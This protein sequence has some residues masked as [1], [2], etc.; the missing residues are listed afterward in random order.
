MGKW[1]EQM[2]LSAHLNS[3]TNILTK[4]C[5]KGYCKNGGKCSFENG[6]P[7]CECLNSSFTGEKCEKRVAEDL[8]NPNPCLNDGQ[9]HSN[10]TTVSCFCLEAF[11]GSRCEIPCKCGTNELCR[12]SIRSPG[13]AECLTVPEPELIIPDNN[14]FSF[15]ETTNQIDDDETTIITESQP[16][17]T[18]TNFSLPSTTLLTQNIN[19]SNN[20]FEVTPT[21]I[22]SPSSSTSFE[23]PTTLKPLTPIPTTT[24]TF[25]PNLIS[26]S[27]IITETDTFD[28]LLN[29]TS[30]D[31]CVNAQRCL[32]MDNRYICL[33]NEGYTG[34]YCDEP[35]NVCTSIS[36]KDGQV[37]RLQ[38][39][40]SI[41]LPQCAC[42]P[43]FFGISCHD[44]TTASFKPSSILIYQ[45]QSKPLKDSEYSLILSFRTTVP[46]VH[47]V[48]GENLFGK[49]QFSLSLHSGFLTISIG[50]TQTSIN[51]LILDDGEWYTIWFNS[52]QTRITVEI[53]ESAS[54]YILTRK[55]LQIKPINIYTT[56]FGRIN[57]DESSFVGCLRDVFINQQLVDLLSSD[58]SVDIEPGCNR[59]DQCKSDTCQNGAKCIDLWDK[60]RCECVRPFLEP[61]CVNQLQEVTFGHDNISSL[62]EFS[63]DANDSKLIRQKTDISF[64]I[65]S[66]NDDGIIGFF[67]NRSD[68]DDSVGTFLSFEIIDG[69]FVVN[70]R[71]G[72]KRIVTEKSEKSINDNKIH[73]IEIQRSGNDLRLKID[74][75]QEAIL[76]FRHPFEHPLLADSLVLGDRTSI[77]QEAAFTSPSGKHFKG[78]L[79]D[80]RINGKSVIL[81][82]DPPTF[83]LES[84]GQK[85]IDQNILEGTVSD[86]IC[87]QLNPCQQGKCFNTFNDFECQCDSGW[88]GLKCEKK[89]FC[90]DKPCP[91]G[92][93]CENSHGGYVC[94]STASF[95]PTS[96]VKYS[97][98]LPEIVAPSKAYANFTIQ[99]RTRSKIGQIFKLQSSLD[100]I[101]F[102]LTDFGIDVIYSNSTNSIR[103][104]LALPISDGQWHTFSLQELNSK[105]SAEFDTFPSTP[106]LA[107]FSLTRFGIDK[108]A[109]LVLG[110]GFNSTG[111]KGCLQKITFNDFP[112]ISF[113]PK[114]TFSGNLNTVLHFVPIQRENIQS[115]GCHSTEK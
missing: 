31:S 60:F 92:S 112:E 42:A 4:Q 28:E 65:R 15:L 11:T 22:V 55:Q 115:D 113:L 25:N 32:E 18:L 14:N 49:Q 78:T 3:T 50:N 88:I 73:L 38:R 95:Y 47:F 109:R 69:K 90:I 104:P 41:D 44:A 43:G 46:N 61:M 93:T 39:T 85:Q 16:S 34:A 10:G 29:V 5:P 87:A 66:K 37:C 56:R 20:S 80:I 74:G 35:S 107:P 13:T 72:G 59:K 114:D 36:C 9:C 1:C 75:K 57:E 33:C 96:V 83:N 111:F 99:I 105:L 110:K 6:H 64:L 62:I 76:Q 17:T 82:D 98:K 91:F 77:K 40:G 100:S 21:T 68:D 89:D 84:F 67:G 54:G 53:E 24:T 8:C 2:R 103:D 97:L 101:S 102:M 30:C 81:A 79:Q 52:S 12:E 23:I 51:D 27:T 108:N 70:G 63:I 58:R 71:L 7:K 26:S 45:S 19:N 94:I 86:D 106:L 48:T